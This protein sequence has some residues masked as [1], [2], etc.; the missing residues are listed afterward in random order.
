MVHGKVGARIDAVLPPRWTLQ[1]FRITSVSRF[2]TLEPGDIIMAGTPEGVG[3]VIPGDLMQG[4]VAGPGAK[5][6]RIATVG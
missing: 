5:L 4:S 6:V 3:A 2:E 1:L